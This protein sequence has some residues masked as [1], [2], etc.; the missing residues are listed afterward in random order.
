MHKD[1]TLSGFSCFLISVLLWGWTILFTFTF[2]FIDLLIFFPLSLVFDRGTGGMT[3]LASRAWGWLIIF[4]SM[5]WKLD[6][7][8][9]RHIDPKKQ[10]VIVGNHQSLLD[11]L[12]VAA[13]IPLNFK[14]LAKKELFH[15]PIMGWAMALAGYIP[16]DRSS[17]ES[18]KRALLRITQYLKKGASVLLFPEGTRSLDGK[19]HAFKTGAF[20]LS[21]ETGCPILPVVIEG[22]GQ[23]LPKSSFFIKKKSTFTI[24]IGEPVDLSD[25]GGDSLEDAKEKIRHEM[26]GRLEKIRHSRN[27]RRATFNEKTSR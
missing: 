19:I 1:E 21:R 5:I 18:G 4:T 7:R 24:S 10:Y 22:T 17:H 14:F 9:L 25:L 8:G 3:H 2:F 20:K 11:I 27:A 6:V 26:A 23:A 15:I 16:V 13:T 12:V